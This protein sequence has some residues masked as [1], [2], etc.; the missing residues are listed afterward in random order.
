[1]IQPKWNTYAANHHCGK[2]IAPFVTHELGA[3][4]LEE[5]HFPYTQSFVHSQKTGLFL[6][7]HLRAHP[8]SGTGYGVRKVV[9][10]RVLCLH[11]LQ[12]SPHF[13][14]FFILEGSNENTH[15][16]ED[17]TLPIVNAESSNFTQ[18]RVSIQGIVKSRHAVLGINFCCC[19]NLN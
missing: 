10:L 13:F 3:L 5:N 16:V 9:S 8:T 18:H 11:V 14:L 2:K 4:L 15:R 7:A 17:V 6:K 12:T 1:M 19:Y